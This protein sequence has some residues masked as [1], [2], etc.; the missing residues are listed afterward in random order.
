MESLTVKISLYTFDT[1]SLERF[2]FEKINSNHLT[3]LKN[4]TCDGKDTA[5][6]DSIDFCL[7][8]LQ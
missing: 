3:I 8:K 5:L 4:L 2:D 7:D 1:S 6:F